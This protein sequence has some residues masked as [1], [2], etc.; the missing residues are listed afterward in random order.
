MPRALQVLPTLVTYIDCSKRKKRPTCCSYNNV[1]NTVANHM[2]PVKLAFMLSIAEELEPFLAEFQ[3]KKPMVPFLA[4]ALDGLLHSLLGRIVT[5]ETLSA[6][7]MPSKLL[8][9]DLNSENII[10]IAAFDIGFGRPPKLLKIDLDKCNNMIATAAFDI[11]FAAKTELWK[12]A[13]PSQI[14]MVS[15]KKECISS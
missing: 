6:A 10:A 1:E 7:D 4:S 3:S 14:A 11:G 12:L 2:L 8:K 5:K 15:F 9:I 13:K